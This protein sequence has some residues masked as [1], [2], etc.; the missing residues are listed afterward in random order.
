MKKVVM[1]VLTSVL[2]SLA[3]ENT[4][5]MAS[6]DLSELSGES[7][8]RSMS[9][10]D[11]SSWGTS[12]YFSLRHI[13][14]FWRW[15]QVPRVNKEDKT[16]VQK[17]DK[18]FWKGLDDPLIFEC[19]SYLTLKEIL[20]SRLLCKD[21]NRNH[22]INTTTKHLHRNATPEDIEGFLK[23]PIL[24]VTIHQ[25]IISHHKTLAISR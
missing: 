18:T 16:C 4:A 17:A 10:S 14:S 2:V 13:S 7:S 15:V 24:K 19:G 25:E 20:K 8:E 3:I 9:L 11:I 5:V 12:S 23:N 6:G 21:F 22:W 1:S